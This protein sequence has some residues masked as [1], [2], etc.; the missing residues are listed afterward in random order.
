MNLSLRAKLR[1]PESCSDS[2]LRDACGRYLI[3]YRGVWENATDPSVKE[4]ARSKLEDLIN[5]ASAEN[6]PLQE[7]EFCTFREETPNI[8]ADVEAELASMG[9]GETLTSAQANHLNSIIAKRP[10]SAK[11]YY[12]SAV[13]CL[14]SGVA[15][16]EKYE[17]A[18]KLLQA[19]LRLD[20]ENFAYQ[21]MLENIQQEIQAYMDARVVHE[22]QVALDI[23]REENKVKRR[24]IFER[25]GEVLLWIGGG[26]LAV[27]GVLLSCM[28]SSC[29]GC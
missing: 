13:V 14:R 27:G 12:L 22:Q 23:Q 11:R 6:I 17:N 2:Q 20:P 3:I 8:C 18:S 26:I 4:I 21:S 29:D 16:V 10:E 28:C 5:H 25:V 15:S 24:Q 7:L 19:A 9:S 1:L